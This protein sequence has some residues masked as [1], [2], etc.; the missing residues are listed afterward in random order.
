[1]EE[2]AVARVRAVLAERLGLSPAP[3][4]AESRAAAVAA[5]GHPGDVPAAISFLAEALVGETLA[6]RSSDR[7]RDTVD[8]VATALDLRRDRLQ[9][10]TF[11]AAL[12]S[13][14]L[15]DLPPRR[16][17]ELI[18]TLL[19]VIANIDEAS[20]WR[21]GE[22]G[23]PECLALVGSSS[24]TRRV[25]AVAADA[26]AGR[27]REPARGLLHSVPVVQWNDTR[28]VIV[29]RTRAAD[30]ERGLALGAEAARA[31]V[32]I[33]EKDA[34]LQQN[35]R[36]EQALVEAS[37]KRLVRLA[38]DLHDGALQDLAALA[39][40]LRLFRDA[41]AER[42]RVRTELLV[43]RVDDLSARVAAVEH[44]LREIAQ[45][46]HSPSLMRTPFAELVQAHVDALGAAGVAVTFE[47]E[48]AVDWFTPSVRIALIR[49]IEAAFENIR[50]H[51]GAR[52]ATLTIAS[53]PNRAR[54]EIV[55]DGKGFDLEPTLTAAAHAGRLGLIGMSE[56]IRLLGGRFDIKSRP[57]GPTTIT[58][59]VPRWRDGN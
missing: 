25:R 39:V 38:F 20:L 24:P 11:V 55:D 14:S 53:D 7:L 27:G 6:G 31:L 54:L 49:L 28:A 15:S 18:L 30:R 48:G 13:P 58:V 50:A 4:V 23:G 8:A 34:L 17:A 57:G 26:L 44:D 12:A 51:S 42:D 9:A 5:L 43:G 16:A 35:E 36:R 56:R 40:E 22:D 29:I 1:M 2:T 59:V 46:F 45:S 41:V 52:N 33:V 21:I 32:P 47:L 37:E 10:E 19:T 3:A